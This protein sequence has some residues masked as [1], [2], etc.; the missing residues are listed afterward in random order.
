MWTI[1]YEILLRTSYDLLIVWKR[2]KHLEFES[3]LYSPNSTN[4]FENLKYYQKT[5]ID[6]V[7][8]KFLGF[9]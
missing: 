5:P 3:T 4:D 6:Y 2:L 7:S 9:S 8:G 1:D